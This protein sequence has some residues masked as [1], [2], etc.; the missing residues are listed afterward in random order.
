MNKFLVRILSVMLA[1]GSL[2]ACGQEGSTSVESSDSQQNESSVMAESTL[3]KVETTFSISY[4]SYMQES[5]GEALVLDQRPEN[6]VV[7]SNSALQILIR[8]EQQPIAVTEPTSF[9]EYPDWV[10]DLPVISTGKSTL[11]TESVI[12]MEPDLVIMGVHLKEDYGAQL[13]EAG[14]PV[15]YTSEGPSITYEEVKEE[16]IALTQSFGTE[17]QVSL[18]EVDFEMLE[19][20]VAEFQS[21]METKQMMILFG[22][23]PSYQQ[24]S[25]GYLGS[26]LNMLPFENLSDTLVDPESRTTPLDLEKLVELNPEVLFAISPTAPAADTL[27][28]VYEEEFAKNPDIWNN[29]QAVQN[30]NLIWL[31]SEYVTSKGIQ[32]INTMNTLMDMLEEKFGL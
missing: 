21:V 23:P 9:V 24:T 29:L 2:V 22:A 27:K 31:S 32:I 4:P 11:D 26:I 16:A 28:Q 19:K 5:E 6:I 1:A 25:K 18:V 12:S 10:A 7:L 13:N 3:E 17:E 15:Y 14:I 20:R 8:C 30:D